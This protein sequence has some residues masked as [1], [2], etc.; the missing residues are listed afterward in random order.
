MSTNLS[1]CLSY[2]VFFVQGVI[3]VDKVTNKTAPR[4]SI[5]I[6]AF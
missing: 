1:K 4:T 3:C 5:D 6:Y 2:P